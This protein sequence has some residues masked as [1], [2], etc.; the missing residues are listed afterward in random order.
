MAAQFLSLCGS[1]KAALITGRP[2]AW[3]HEENTAG[4]LDAAKL[5]GLRCAATAE[6]FDDMEI[7]YRQTAD[8]LEQYPDL[9]GI[10]TSSYV[11]PGVCRRVQETGRRIH[12]VGTD[13]VAGSDRCLRAGILTA[14]IFQNQATQARLAAEMVVRIFREGGLHGSEPITTLVKPE[15]VLSSSLGCYTDSDIRSE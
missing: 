7:A 14:T 4:F 15:L 13:L 10:F 3:I 11:A 5:Y 6:S 8:M 12:I 9:D 2:Q 1:Q